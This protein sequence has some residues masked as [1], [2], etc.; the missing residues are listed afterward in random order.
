M[1]LGIIAFMVEIFTV[2]FIAGA[3]GIGN[4][5]GDSAAACIVNSRRRWDSR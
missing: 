3:I 1:A 2:G 5:A 4:M